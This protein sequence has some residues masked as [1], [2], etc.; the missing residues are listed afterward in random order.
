MKIFDSKIIVYQISSTNPG[1][2]LHHRWIW[3]VDL[4]FSIVMLLNI[5]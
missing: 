3:F 2:S 5:K 4:E 1:H